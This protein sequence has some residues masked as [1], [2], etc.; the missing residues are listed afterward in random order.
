MHAPLR[1]GFPVE[2]RD[3]SALQSIAEE[4]RE[5]AAH[6][7]EPNV[8]YEP[9]F[10]LA[11]A[12]V[13]GV[14][15]RAVL[16]RNALGKL[17]GLFPGHAGR[18]KVAGWVHPYA[19][20]GTPLVDRNE[21]EAVIGAWLGHLGRDP[22][23]PAQLLLPLVP[24]QG[25][26]ARALD[27]VLTQA[28]RRSAAFGR[29]ER[30]LLAPGDERQAYLERSMSAGKRKELRRQRRRL[31]D[32]GPVTVTTASAMAD[33]DAIAATITLTSGDTAWCWKIA[34]NEGLARSSPG[35]QLIC[36]LTDSLFARSEPRRVDSCAAAGHPMIDHV[37]RE[38]LMLSDR[39]IELRPS[40][41]P[42]ALACGI[43]TA[44]RAA[45][46]TAKSLRD[47]LRGR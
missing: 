40:A 42:F 39:L 6:A 41:M 28:G 29:H 13:F 7:L 44:R 17:V 4:W 38:R 8:F 2:W 33:I 31:E 9:A 15:T 1:P 34:Y 27:A 16:V 14:D 18:L 5:L 20:L 19:P 26:F 32:V 46:A 3:L 30:A 47:R 36:D 23:M 11:A 10:A 24:E 21:P 25:A 12:P 45:I 37:W 35:V 22:A 43:E